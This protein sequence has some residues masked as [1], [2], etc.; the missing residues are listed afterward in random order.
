MN[1]TQSVWLDR[2]VLQ[3]MIQD[4]EVLNPL[5]HIH[6]DDDDDDMTGEG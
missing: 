2:N 5:S 6:D 4:D 3:M 1:D